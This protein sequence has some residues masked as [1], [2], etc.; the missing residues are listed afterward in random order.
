MG[1]GALGVTGPITAAVLVAT[2]A[3]LAWVA[4]VT[5]ALSWWGWTLL[6]LAASIFLLRFYTESRRAWAISGIKQ[7]S[8][9]TAAEMCMAVEAKYQQFLQANRREIEGVRAGRYSRGDDLAARWEE[10]SKRED[11]LAR[12]LRGWIGGDVAAAVAVLNALGIKAESDLRS[13]HWADSSARYFGAMG[14]LLHKGLLE[15]ARSFDRHK[16]FF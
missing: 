9:E 11:A 14:R 12:D 10:M 15:E 8:T 7:L 2:A 16:L 4:N 3:I 6:G 1:L 13:L 5:T